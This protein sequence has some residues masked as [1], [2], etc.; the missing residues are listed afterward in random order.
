MAD[1][2]AAWCA[3]HPRHLHRLEG[4]PHLQQRLW[5]D[6]WRPRSRISTERCEFDID[7]SPGTFILE[8]PVRLH[9][10]PY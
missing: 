5:L 7:Q 9:S 2:G 3:S 10:V 4:W 8:G 6:L 1:L